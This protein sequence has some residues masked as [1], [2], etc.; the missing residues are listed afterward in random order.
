M[1]EYKIINGFENYE[2]SN[3]GNIINI[4]TGKN[5]KQNQNKQGYMT[6]NI[7]NNDKIY[8]KCLVHR[9]IGF[10][11]ILNPN[12]KPYIDHIDNNRSN[13]NIT[14]LRWCLPIENTF[15]S[16]IPKTN[17]SGFKGVHYDKSKQLWRAQIQK[18][19]KIID[20]GYFFDINDAIKARVDKANI[21]FGDFINQCEKIPEKIK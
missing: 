10:T 3:L 14:N 11:F 1:E 7:I 13:N 5:I 12:N 17:K 18:N 4:K 6:V 19:L 21:L 20:L 9:L 16:K 2:I 8:K 15:N